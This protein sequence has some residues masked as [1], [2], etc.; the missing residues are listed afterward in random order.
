MA[1]KAKANGPVKEPPKGETGPLMQC[2]GCGRVIW[3]NCGPVCKTCDALPP[4][5]DKAGI[6]ELAQKLTEESAG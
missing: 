6:A 4:T 1:K 5:P 2:T 3:A